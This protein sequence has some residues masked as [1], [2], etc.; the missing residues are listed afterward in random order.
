MRREFLYT[1]ATA[2]GT[3]SVAER[4][5]GDSPVAVASEAVERRAGLAA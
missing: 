4:V 2:M 5:D 3:L 1:Q